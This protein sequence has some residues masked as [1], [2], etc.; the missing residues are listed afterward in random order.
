MSAELSGELSSQLFRRFAL[1]LAILVQ[2]PRDFVE[3]RWGS[4]HR[5]FGARKLVGIRWEPLEGVLVEHQVW[6]RDV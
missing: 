1:E 6:H 2:T 5:V 4:H 3:Q